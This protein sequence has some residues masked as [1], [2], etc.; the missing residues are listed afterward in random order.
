MKKLVILLFLLPFALMGKYVQ[1]GTYT[2][3]A[4]GLCYSVAIHYFV[5]GEVELQTELKD[6]K[7]NHIYAA[8]YWGN[9]KASLIDLGEKNCG[10]V[11]TK[12]C[13]PK[14]PIKSVT[15]DGYKCR[16]SPKK[17]NDCPEYGEPKSF[18]IDNAS[19]INFPFPAMEDGKDNFLSND[20]KASA[21]R[22]KNFIY[23]DYSYGNHSDMLTNNQ[24]QYI[25]VQLNPSLEIG[26]I[27]NIWK[28]VNLNIGIGR[29]L[30]H[31]EIDD[32]LPATGFFSTDLLLKDW[33]YTVGTSY[34]FHKK[35]IDV[36]PNIGFYGGRVNSYYIDPPFTTTPYL[37]NNSNA[38]IP[39]LGIDIVVKNRFLI[40]LKLKSNNIPYSRLLPK[41]IFWGNYVYGR[42]NEHRISNILLLNLKFGVGF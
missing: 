15:Q 32:F 8:I 19:S 41:R 33:I 23:L 17:H 11:F 20:S 35:N 13:L 16:I 31:K 18:N 10:L 28:N 26:G 38:I 34:T 22:S 14:R 2:D 29:V 42:R 4:S 12:S 6:I 21:I 9:D 36:I 3:L 5:G 7:T 24:L 25:G 30:N 39:F 27:I 40:G 37:T 1:Q